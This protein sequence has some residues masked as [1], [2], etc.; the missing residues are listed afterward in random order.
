MSDRSRAAGIPKAEL[1]RRCAQG[2]MYADLVPIGK[3]KW[4][5][6]KG[7]DYCGCSECGLGSWEMEF[8]FC[9]HCGADMRKKV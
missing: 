5:T 6:T 4:R 2:T 1:E 3:W 9:P 7:V 8:N